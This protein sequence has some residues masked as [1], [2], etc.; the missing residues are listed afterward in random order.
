MVA[1]NQWLPSQFTHES[2]ATRLLCFPHAGGGSAIYHRWEQQL[3]PHLT[4]LPVKLPGREGRL[5]EPAHTSIAA[6]LTAMTPSIASSI[7]EPY[8]L[9]GHSMGGLIAYELARKLQNEHNKTPKLLFVSACRSPDRFQQTQ[10]LHRLPTEEMIE[11]LIRDFNENGESTPAEREMMRAMADTLRADL[12][13]LETYRHQGPAQ[14]DCPII[15][16][17]GSEDH[18]VT[19]SDVNGWRSFTR[20]AFSLRTIPGHHFFLRQQEQSI[21]QLIASKLPPDA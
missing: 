12:Q 19:A 8:A 11:S 18:K 1:V 2:G 5:R 16:L 17:A 7:T 9:F 13:L 15:G 6:L 14:L 20:A 4:L 10:S 3:P 21:L